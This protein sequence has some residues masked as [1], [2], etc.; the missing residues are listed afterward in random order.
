MPFRK[1]NINIKIQSRV[2]NKH[3]LTCL[4]HVYMLQRMNENKIIHQHFV[5]PPRQHPQKLCLFIFLCKGFQSLTLLHNTQM[6]Y[7]QQKLYYFIK[8]YLNMA[9]RRLNM[10]ICVNRI[11]NPNITGTALLASGHLSKSWRHSGK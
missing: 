2:L 6:Y 7:L 9:M 4:L 1:W 11:Y 10:R 8:T 3:V 5:S